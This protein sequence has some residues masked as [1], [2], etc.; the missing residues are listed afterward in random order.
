MGRLILVSN[1]L[2]ITVKRSGGKTTVTR[3]SGGLVAG[4]GPIHDRGDT[5][6]IGSTDSMRGAPSK[7]EMN[8]QRLIAVPISANDAKRHYEGYSNGVLWPLFH[9]L[10]DRIT[11]DARDF[12]AYRRVNERFA[13]LVT[14]HAGPD[15]QIW[16]HDYQLMLLP[17]MLR[18]R[19]PGTPIGFFLHI[20]FPSSEVFRILPR[21][22]MILRGLLGAN[23][24][25]LHTW[26]YA[27]HLVSSMRRLLGV[28]FNE[29]WVRI[30]DDAC[31]ISVFPLGVDAAGL[32][33]IACRPAVDR[34][35]ELL[36]QQVGDRKVILGVDR[37]DYTKGLPSRL[38]AFQR[39]LETRRKWREKAVLWQLAVPSR[40]SIG[41]YKSLKEEVD[42]L[43]GKIDGEYATAGLSPIQ[44]LYR[45]VLP[46]EL[47]AMYRL[48]DVMLV[49]P[50]RDG[51]N[52]VAKEYVAS[53]LDDTGVLV[54]S[55]FAGAASEMGE[56]LMCNPWNIDGTARAI[57][58]A[59]RM[60]K[61]EMAQRMSALRKR[62][63]QNDVHRWVRRFLDALG[64]FTANRKS[65]VELHTTA[66][67]GDDG[68]W[69][70]NLLDSFA[71]ADNP[72]LAL[73]YDGTLA[74]L[75]PVPEAAAPTPE[76]LQLLRSLG[77]V[78]NVRVV[79]VSGRDP[80][81]LDAWLGDLPVSLVA[82][83]GFRW[84][85]DGA[86]EWE[87]LLIGAD[88]SWK[89]TVRE[90]LEDYTA[91]SVGAFIE[92]KPASLAWHYRQVE[93]GFGRWQ[94]RELGQHLAEAF[95]NSPLEVLHGSKVIEV[96]PQG[97][98]KGRAFRMLQERVGPF[99]FV[100][101]AGDDRTDE[102][103]FLAL[104][105]EAWSIKVGQGPTHAQFRIDRPSSFRALLSEM[106]R[107]ANDRG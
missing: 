92:E 34:H 85:L 21:A 28:E 1:R 6:W 86:K 4:L 30:S 14:E 31:R 103:M 33:E 94:A 97:Y 91:R 63:E 13:D 57:D 88:M 41:M 74:E 95:A 15:D 93:P 35:L 106:C 8:R 104:P 61:A 3:S 65:V 48:A 42:R 2:P 11:F 64:S 87:V 26:D 56:A 96:R 72:L 38:R 36:R 12:E 78:E 5:L 84:R 105:P 101:A 77:D 75:A 83:H 43:V 16:V 47:A 99:D 68:G 71:V 50:I 29:S 58:R 107:R 27:R 45:S 54:L 81:T 80:Q 67:E 100:L 40:S 90:I 18:E 98:D 62:V 24:I 89:A 53:R 59:L 25:G 22:D 44:Y 102:D 17:S 51:M 32:H 46:E 69:I 10:I 49:T 52:L 23:I 73:D 82:E 76:L 7:A 66:R 60:P 70:N 19:L 9:Y 79:I 20:P 37:M 55:E 39:L